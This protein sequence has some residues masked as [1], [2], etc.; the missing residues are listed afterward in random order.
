MHWRLRS[1]DDRNRIGPRA[2]LG[3]WWMPGADFAR[4]VLGRQLLL[5]EGDVRGELGEGGEFVVAWVP[6]D[7]PVD[8]WF[9][10]GGGVC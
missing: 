3:G 7:V 4:A 10:W 5:E 6:E 8:S 1:Y 2:V 9:L